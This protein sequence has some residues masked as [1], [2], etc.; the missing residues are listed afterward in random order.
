MHSLP[1]VRLPD[2]MWEAAKD[3]EHLKDLIRAYI[4]KCYPGYRV[5]KVKGRMAI[6]EIN[7][8]G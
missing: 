2:W 6:C 3:N 7:R 4:N 5:I 8:Q 1:N